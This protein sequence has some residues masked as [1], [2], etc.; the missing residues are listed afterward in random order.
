MSSRG[1]R[2]ATSGAAVRRLTDLE[3]W[4][5]G[6]R[7]PARMLTGVVTGRM[8]EPP[9]PAGDGVLIGEA[10]RHCVLTPKG[11]MVA[12]LR[13][14]AE[15]GAAGQPDRPWAVVPLAAAEGL[16]AHLARYLPPRFAKLE[17]L[18]GFGVVGLIGPD[19]DALVSEI[20]LEGRAPVE[21]LSS[22]PAGGT[23][24]AA[25]SGIR[26][27]RGSESSIPVWHLIGEVSVVER[28]H[29]L[30]EEAGAVPATEDDWRVVRVEGGTPAYGADM[31]EG[32][33]PPE[34][35]LE[36]VAIDHAKGCYTGQEVIV[37]IRDRGHVNRKLLRIP[38]GDVDPPASG[39]EVFVEGREK[40]AAVV[41]SAVRSPRFGGTIALAYVRREVWAG[42]GDP[43]EFSVRSAS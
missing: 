41:R 23:V 20:V 11:R 42:E 25:D 13:L 37:R 43:P 33:I 26:L 5:F 14:A 9:T 6:G 16:R 7:D 38:L 29:G 4:E 1:Y 12:D 17:V 36:E 35:G 34:A 39:T 21:E 40:P 3:V 8:P 2:A 31:D 24:V 27:I 30:L 15:A 28:L 18:D 19:S 32:T 22:L 10:T